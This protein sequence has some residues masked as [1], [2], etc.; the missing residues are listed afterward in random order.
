MLAQQLKETALVPVTKRS[1]LEVS[2]SRLSPLLSLSR[3]TRKNAGS[4]WDRMSSD[5]QKDFTEKAVEES[6]VELSVSAIKEMRDAKALDNLADTRNSE[7]LL[8]IAENPHT[9]PQ[10]LR[11]V[12]SKTSD[13]QVRQALMNNFKTPESTRSYLSA[14][15][16]ERT[17]RNIDWD[18]IHSNDQPLVIPQNLTDSVSGIVR[19]HKNINQ[20]TIT[21]KDGK[22]FKVQTYKSAD[23]EVRMNVNS[24]T[25]EFKDTFGT[26]AE[27]WKTS[28]NPTKADH[29]YH[30]LSRPRFV[31][32]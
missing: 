22:V 32:F 8:A 15:G 13:V 3:A 29:I 11:K 31:N 6:K 26:Y 16:F 28:Q 30:L 25:Q 24:D 2:K 17:A 18:A 7:V 19:S 1:P 5:E 27:I 9:S 4:K 12:Y 14:S 23:N 10:T 20:F 21:A